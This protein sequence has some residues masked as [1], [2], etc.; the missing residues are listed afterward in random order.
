MKKI[1][2]NSRIIGNELFYLKKVL[3]NNFRAS[4]STEFVKKLELYFAKKF[5]SKFAIS[6]SDG[7]AT[8]HAALEAMNIG[9]G[10][11]VIVPPLTMSSTT[12]AVLHSNAKPIFAD[13]D[14]KTFQIDPDNIEKKITKKTKAIITVAL[15]GLSP[16]L[17]RIK[18]IASK[19]KLK[20]IEDNAECFMGFYKK[21]I[22]GTIGDCASFSFQNSKH[23]TCGKGG[24]LITKNPLLAKNIRTIQSLGYSFSN[25]KIKKFNKNILQN[26]KFE[27]HSALGWNYRLPEL[28]AAVALAQMENLEYFVNQRRKIAAL[29]TKA[30]EKFKWFIPQYIPNNCKSSYW[31]WAAYSKKDITWEEFRDCYKKNGGDGIYGAWKLAYEEPFY[32]K[33]NLNKRQNFINLEKNNNCPNAEYLQP[34][35]FQFKTNYM[36]LAIAKKQSKILYKTLNFF[37]KKN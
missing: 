4:K 7:T 8:M 26:P 12:L 20:I 31:T 1:N 19:Y 5:K 36:N 9:Y 37:D 27:R 14:L 3:N 32:K 34:K 10:D 15:Y 29:Y 18:K 17:D 33:E 2:Q 22:V 13:V 21:K 24:I 28:C 23:I 30:S 35:L 11:E 25:A 6:F 16:D